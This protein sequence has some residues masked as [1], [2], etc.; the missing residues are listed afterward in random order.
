MLLIQLARDICYNMGG[1]S[2]GS[3]IVGAK[4]GSSDCRRNRAVVLVVALL[5]VQVLVKRRPDTTHLTGRR[6]G[7]LAGGVFSRDIPLVNK[8]ASAARMICRIDIVV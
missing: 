8:P 2:R 4:G 1:G 7:N 5:L 6:V 3:V